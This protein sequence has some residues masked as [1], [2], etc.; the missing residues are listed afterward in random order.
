MLDVTQAITMKILN[1]DRFSRDDRLVISP[2]DD[3][4]R[5]WYPLV[6]TFDGESDQSSPE[7]YM[8]T[9]ETAVHWTNISIF[10]WKGAPADVDMADDE[11]CQCRDQEYARS[12]MINFELAQYGYATRGS[13]WSMGEHLQPRTTWSAW[14]VSGMIVPHLTADQEKKTTAAVLDK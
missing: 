4:F 6:C 12:R 11:E 13:R 1:V 14:T 3:Q 2:R 10:E 8:A 5:T 9:P 7:K